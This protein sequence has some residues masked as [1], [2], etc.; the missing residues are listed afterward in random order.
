MPLALV[1]AEIRPGDKLE[2]VRVK[3]GAPRGQAESGG[4]LLLYYERGEVE[5]QDGVV[6]RVALLSRDAHEA[7]SAR[8]AAEAQSLREAEE[9]RRARLRAEGEALKAR[10]L[11]DPDFRG[12]SAARQVAFWEDFVRRYPDVPGH[13]ELLLARL[14]LAEQRQQERREA[15]NTER[16][17]RLEARLAESE[18][19][20]LAAEQR[21]ERRVYRSFH[22]GYIRDAHPHNL[23]PIDY[24]DFNFSHPLG[25]PLRKLGGSTLAEQETEPREKGCN[26]YLRRH[27]R[28][29]HRP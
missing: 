15:E 26:R 3:L 11:A 4:R 7:E 14:R 2:Q 9:I 23:W 22:P 27:H 20:A 5:L 18:A 8:R 25:T 13:E 17:A 12:A 21:P 1:A 29:E 10:Q 28:S 16:F 19:R 6:T 24:G